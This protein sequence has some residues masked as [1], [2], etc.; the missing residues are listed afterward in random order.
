MRGAAGTTR[1][2]TIRAVELLFVVGELL[3]LLPNGMQH[4]YPPLFMSLI[5]DA[6]LIVA[7]HRAFVGQHNILAMV[8]YNKYMLDTGM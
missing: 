1:I 4:C 2:L 3:F 8:N 6:L 7:R 5:S